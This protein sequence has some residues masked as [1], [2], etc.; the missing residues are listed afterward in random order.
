ME[1]EVGVEGEGDGRGEEVDNYDLYESKTNSNFGT[2]NFLSGYV[3]V[4]P[5]IH[6]SSSLF[7]YLLMHVNVNLSNE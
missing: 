3:L 5:S 7:I 4:F 6:L 1:E 2:A